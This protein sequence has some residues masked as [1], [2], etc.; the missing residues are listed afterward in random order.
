MLGSLAVSARQQA[1]ISRFVAFTVCRPQAIRLFHEMAV[2]P[3]IVC[4]RP[5]AAWTMSQR[6]SSVTW[7]S[8]VC[9]ANTE[10]LHMHLMD[11]DP[12]FNCRSVVAAAKCWGLL[13]IDLHTLVAAGNNLRLILSLDGTG[14]FSIQAVVIG[15][16]YFAS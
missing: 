11:L 8:S 15:E 3:S 12:F 5:L 13:S 9:F 6:G 4:A 2:E 7:L 10:W 14:H 16:H 1:I